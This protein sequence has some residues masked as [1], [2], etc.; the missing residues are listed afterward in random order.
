MLRRMLPNDW[1]GPAYA[2]AYRTSIPTP[3]VVV[4]L[5]GGQLLCSGRRRGCLGRRWPERERQRRAKRGFE[6]FRGRQ[7]PRIGSVLTGVS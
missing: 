5:F 2:D 4:D 1:D 6:S 7:R 3:L